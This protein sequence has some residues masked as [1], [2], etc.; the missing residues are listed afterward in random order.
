MLKTMPEDATV[1]VFDPEM[2]GKTVYTTD[3]EWYVAHNLL[4][5]RRG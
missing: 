5:D 3:D 2:K 1:E 4:N